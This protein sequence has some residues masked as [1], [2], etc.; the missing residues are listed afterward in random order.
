MRQNRHLARQSEEQIINA[1]I[2]T[3]EVIYKGL[4]NKAFKPQKV[5]IPT[6]FESVMVVTARRLE[7]GKIN[8][9][10]QLGERYL[11]LTE[12]D[13]F[14][15]VAQKVRNLTSQENVR[16]RLEIASYYLGNLE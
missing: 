4:G 16:K 13:N 11:S 1:F 10:E 14:S 8:N 12:D 9:L 2:P 7:Q 15:G 3:I 6:Y 5:L